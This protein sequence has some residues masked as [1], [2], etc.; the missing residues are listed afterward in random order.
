[1][2]ISC[3]DRSNIMKKVFD[4]YNICVRDVANYFLSL[5]DT[6]AGDGISNLKL[7]KLLYYAQGFVLALTGKKLFNEN[8]IAWQ[9]GP[10]VEEMYYEFKGAGSN[11][12]EITISDI[13]PILNNLEIK[14]ILDEVFQVYG[15]FSAWKLRNMTHQERPWQTTPQSELIKDEVIKEFFDTLVA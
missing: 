5:C 8:I 2:S 14:E 12:I 3:N 15:Q 7:Q 9:H 13:S 6:D 10:V 11:H 4:S 1:M